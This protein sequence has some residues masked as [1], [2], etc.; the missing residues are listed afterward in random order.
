MF[1]GCNLGL[2]SR[3]IPTADVSAGQQLVYVLCDLFSEADED[4]SGTLTTDE[5]S[6][7][8]RKYYHSEAVGRSLK[9]VGEEVAMA[10]QSY[11]V[12]GSGA[13]DLQEFSRM[14][15]ESEC[16]NF[17]VRRTLGG[18]VSHS[19]PDLVPCRSHSACGTRLRR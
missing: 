17:K 2:G 5:L 6:A 8:L 19:D 14:V 3:S 12:D 9:K 7:L 16:F 18:A 4:A 10:M 11:D 1:N 13:L 15:C